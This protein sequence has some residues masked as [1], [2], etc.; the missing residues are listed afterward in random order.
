[1]D[2][3]I[4]HAL[5]GNQSRLGVLVCH[6][7]FTRIKYREMVVALGINYFPWSYVVASSLSLNGRFI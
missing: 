4:L 5:V 7:H 2:L 3:K 6:A 1:M